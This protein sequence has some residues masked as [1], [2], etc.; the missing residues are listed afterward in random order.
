MG[1][2]K[3]QFHLLLTSAPNG[4][5][6]DSRTGPITQGKG[7]PVFVEMEAGMDPVMKK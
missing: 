6:G 2:V 1:G 4:E 7:A 3:L 5:Q